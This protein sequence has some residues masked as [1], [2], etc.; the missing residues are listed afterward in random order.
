MC[1]GWTPVHCAA[2]G[3]HL[4]VLQLLAESGA[5]VTARDDY[6]DTAKLIARRYAHEECVT[7][8]ER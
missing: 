3:G 4:A 8:L 5:S 1:M 7:Y 2:E 6:G